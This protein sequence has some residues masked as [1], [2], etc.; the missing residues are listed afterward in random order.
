M[1]IL[2]TR[3]VAF[4]A[5]HRLAFRDRSAEENRRSFGA[6]AEPHEHRYTCA[7]TVA[8]T[9]ASGTGMVMDLPALDRIL[10]DE[11]TGRLGGTDL[12]QS[13]DAA[14]TGSALPVC[15]AIAAELFGRIGGR[16]PA[17][18]SLDRVRVEEA[19]DLAAECR[20]G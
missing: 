14:R 1:R 20:A 9:P 3:S 8:G 17:G 11:V 5:R 15:E 10:A 19:P 4:T 6:L 12:N 18:V 2:L 13:L 16:L 7:I